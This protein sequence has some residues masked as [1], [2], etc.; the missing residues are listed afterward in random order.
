MLIRTFAT[1]LAGLVFALSA[2]PARA[3]CSLEW[4]PLPVTMQG[5][6]PVV[7]A[8]I[9]GAVTNFVLDSGAFYSSIT[10]EFAHEHKLPLWAAPG[11]FMVEG[12]GG[13][14]FPEMT[15][16][17]TFTIGGAAIPNVYFLVV[18]GSGGQAAGLL[19]ENVLSILDVDYDLA[20]GMLRIIRPKDCGRSALAYWAGDGAFSMLEIEPYEGMNR[21]IRADIIVN[22][23]RLRAIFDTGFGGSAMTL[24]AAK[25][26]GVKPGDPDVEPAGVT[27]GIGPRPVKTWIA[28]FA[29]VKIG[30]EEI[31]NTR[32]RIADIADESIDIFIGADFFLSHH[33]YVA[34]SQ[35][36]LYFTYNG[37]PVFDL[38]KRPD[39]PDA[40]PATSAGKT[41]AAAEPTDA[42]GFGRRG[43]ASAARG[44]YAKAIADLSRALALTPSEPRY[45]YE[46]AMAYFGDH[47]S[48]LAFADLDQAL[49]LKPDD[50]DALMMRA[51]VRLARKNTAS[52]ATD[53][54]AAARLAPKEADLRLQL[55]ELY[56]QAGQFDAAIAQYDLWISAHPDEGQQAEA[57]NGRCW[58][59]ALAGRDLDKALADCNRALRAVPRMA[60]ILDSR[61]MVHLRRGDLQAAVADYD[62]ALALNPKIAWSLYGRG[63]AKLRL[64]RKADGDADV[65]AATAIKA[66]LPD[67]AK[68]YGIAQPAG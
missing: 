13:V 56:A 28:P 46:R 39:A 42:D 41:V 44:D 40:S 47:Q 5:L 64:G 29:M 14:A 26:A 45:F 30:G 4:S 2:A 33:I 54:D 51:E 21:L 1:A 7:S 32:F 34:N 17:K 43:A 48:T 35:H 18:G 31:R 62:A 16:V 36:R 27:S 20:N 25:R 52:A 37:G 24:A 38:R 53:L 66:D 19:G 59:R 57:L 8:Q 60:T 10:P 15:T 63:L 12:V 3:E 68:Q 58:V 22:G 11:G 49:K 61:G 50:I 55:G 65:A 6:R 23:A 9:N 67:L